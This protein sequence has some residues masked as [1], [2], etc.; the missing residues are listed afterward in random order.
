MISW[1]YTYLK[2][3][4]EIPTVLEYSPLPDYVSICPLTIPGLSLGNIF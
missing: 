3:N 4:E 2:T 1:T